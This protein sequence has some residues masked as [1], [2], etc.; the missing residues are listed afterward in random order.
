M[1]SGPIPDILDSLYLLFKEST[2]ISVV[3]GTNEH[4][5]TVL[6][7]SCGH[8]GNIHLY[9]YTPHISLL[10][11]SADL[12][13]TKPGGITTS[14]AAAKGLPMVLINTVGGCEEHNL[15]YFLSKGGAV[16]ANTTE[17][18]C[19]C[20][21]SLLDNAELRKKMSRTLKEVSKT[22]AAETIYGALSAVRAEMAPDAEGGPGESLVFR[23][24]LMCQQ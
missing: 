24:S 20:C 16:T 4:L 17:E 3:C 15:S 1:G 8:L 22:D 19:R 6:R 9:G 12:L 23:R 2:Q 11:D 18:L 13:V 21:Q 10:M 7:S 5:L 14:E